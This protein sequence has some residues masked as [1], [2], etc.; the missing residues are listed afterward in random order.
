MRKK[1]TSSEATELPTPQ[2]PPA[3]HSGDRVGVA[4][5]SGPVDPDRLDA[6]LAA[7]RE[8]G[9]E[10][11]EASNLRSRADLF[12]GDDR[13]RLD[14]FHT[15]IDDPDLRAVLF[16]R[17]GHGVLRLL[18]HLDWDLVARYP[19]AYVGYSDL[20][21]FLLHV[22]QHLGIV[23]FHGPMVAAD[24]SQGLTEREL[25][26]FEDALAGR[27][28]LT[29]ELHPELSSGKSCSGPLLG[30]CLS[31]LTSTLG[32][33]WAARLDGALLMFEEIDEPLYRLDRMLTHL[34]LSGSLEGIEGLVLGHVTYR[35]AGRE[36]WI[37]R[38]SGHFHRPWAAGLE[39]GHA[40]LNLTLP[41]GL[42]ACL[43]PEAGLL[44]IDAPLE[45][46]RRGY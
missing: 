21:A 41:L 4:A 1:N 16:A 22:T 40:K 5:L 31:L 18:P 23:T 45:M 10:P 12:A 6:G 19:R 36:D 35:N 42:T 37:R 11:V 15:L 3:L 14:A 34:H 43:D 29:Y 26:S 27:F 44:R 20:T 2:M 9:Y 33:P 8:L 7:L 13:E 38:L 25:Q 32:T 39:A 28:P 17:G 30:G 46:E 24:F